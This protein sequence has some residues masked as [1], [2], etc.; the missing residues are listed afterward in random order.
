MLAG[1][2]GQG[3]AKL[4]K[5]VREIFRRV[6]TERADRTARSGVVARQGAI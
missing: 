3:A 1:G 5:A 4:A 6:Q 2:P